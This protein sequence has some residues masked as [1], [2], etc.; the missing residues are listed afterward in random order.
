MTWFST[1]TEGRP[2]GEKLKK[3]LL[4]REE[5]VSEIQM[6]NSSSLRSQTV[7][8]AKGRIEDLIALAKKV[9]AVD[10]KLGRLK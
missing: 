4:Q 2:E 6:L 10:K 1:E 5:L 7:S 8:A 3:L 9:T